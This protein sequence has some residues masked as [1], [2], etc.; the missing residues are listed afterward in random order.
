[1]DRSICEN[2]LFKQIIENQNEAVIIVSGGNRIDY[3]NSKF[4]NEFKDEIMTLYN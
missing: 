3:V 1:M 4:L 2:N